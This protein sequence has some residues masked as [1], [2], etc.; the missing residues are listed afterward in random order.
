VLPD[1]DAEKAALDSAR[2]RAV[3]QP[4]VATAEARLAHARDMLRRREE[5][6]KEQF[7]SS[8]DRDEALGVSAVRPTLKYALSTGATWFDGLLASFRFRK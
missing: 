5:L 4:N 3:M 2:Y 7:V 1:T 8:Q 6:V